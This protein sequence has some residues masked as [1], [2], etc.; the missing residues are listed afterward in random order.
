MSFSYTA[1][2]HPRCLLQKHRSQDCFDQYIGLVQE[3]GLVQADV[4]KQMWWVQKTKL[5]CINS[6]TQGMLAFANRQFHD[7]RFLV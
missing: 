3:A 7:F 6:I 1:L 5:I 4:G 2:C